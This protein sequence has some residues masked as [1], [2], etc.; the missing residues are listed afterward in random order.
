MPSKENMI[1]ERFFEKVELNV[2]ADIET[3]GNKIAKFILKEGKRR[4][5]VLNNILT[6]SGKVEKEP[7][8]LKWFITFG[9]EAEAYALIRHEEEYNL[10]YKSQAKQ[11]REGVVVGTG[12]LIR[13]VTENRSE[14]NKKAGT[15]LK[16]KF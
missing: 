8:E 11:M 1:I 3:K 4:T 2:L 6:K 9:G 13:A 12:Y 15:K 16:V 10:G 14:I 5:P 7:E